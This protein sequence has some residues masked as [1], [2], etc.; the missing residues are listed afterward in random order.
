MHAE[1]RIIP[2]HQLLH[3][4]EAD[5]MAGANIFRARVAEA[6]HKN[7]GVIHTTQSTMLYPQVK[8]QGRRG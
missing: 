6:H 7:R 1:I 5:V 2:G 8:P 3:H 4:L